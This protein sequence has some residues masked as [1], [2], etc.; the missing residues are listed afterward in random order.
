[1]PRHYDVIVLGRSLGALTTAALLARRD[2]TVLVLG[3]GTEP[4]TYQAAGFTFFR[5]AFTFLA[6]GCPIWKKVVGE[7]AQSQTLGRRMTTVDPMMQ[8]LFPRRRFEIPANAELFDREVAREF[9][10]LTRPIGELYDGLSR[11]N[12]AADAVFDKDAVWPPEGFWERRAAT[13]HARA[14]P[15]AYAEPDAD[16]LADFP[17]GHDYRSIVRATVGF[18]TYLSTDS[19]PFASAR[20]HGSW[21]RGLLGL[22]GGESDVEDFLVERI[23]THGGR[24]LMSRRAQ[25]VTTRRGATSGVLIDLDEAPTGCDFV[26]TDMDGESLAATSGGQGI[27]KR[28]LRDW[29]RI[30]STVGRF[31]VSMVVRSAGLPDPLGREMFLFG[32]ARR[33]ATPLVIHVQRHDDPADPERAHLVCEI[34]MKDHGPIAVID[35]RAEILRAVTRTLPYL[36]DHLLAVDS[37]HDGL[38][39]WVFQGQERVDVERARFGL[40]TGERMVRQLEVD[41]PGFLGIAGEPVRGPVERSLLVGRSVLPGL[42]QEGELLAAWCAARLV[43][44]SDRRPSVLRRDSW[45]RFEL[46]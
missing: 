45:A 7:L 19:P 34:L 42:G 3:Q 30:T 1:M 8:A 28:A 12:A 37:P 39:V 11:V 2:F 24:C 38:P 26:V 17:R 31:V 6:A 13:R 10:E 43:T 22:P 15:Y 21:T 41:P 5:R 4:A 35:A 9:P 23:E 32:T 36:E 40:A 46:G 33:S 20:L 29:P 18:S 44:K 16:L 27:R 25:S 14:L